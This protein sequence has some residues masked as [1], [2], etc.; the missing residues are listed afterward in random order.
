M[1]LIEM[2]RGITSQAVPKMTW[3]ALL[4]LVYSSALTGWTLRFQSEAFSKLERSS[5]ETRAPAVRPTAKL[6]KAPIIDF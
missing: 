1:D 4:I 5:C 2:S 6:A 3:P